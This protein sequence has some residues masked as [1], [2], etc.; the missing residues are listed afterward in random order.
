MLFIIMLGLISIVSFF[1]SAARED[2]S[3]GT[4]RFIIFALVA[5]YFNISTYGATIDTT[6]IHDNNVYTTMEIT[7]TTDVTTDADI[8]EVATIW[9][10]QL[11]LTKLQNKQYDDVT[12]YLEFLKMVHKVKVLYTETL[13]TT[14][15]K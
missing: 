4:I 1:I 9:E 15:Y 3:S 6:L 13:R 5:I 12:K 10:K 8:I 14:V 7:V 2:G 11:L